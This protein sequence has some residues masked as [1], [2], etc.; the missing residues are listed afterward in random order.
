MSVKI[1]N[2]EICDDEFEI[3]RSNQKYCAKCRKNPD[4]ARKEYEW[5]AER[6]NRHAGWNDVDKTLKTHICI[7]CG[8]EFLSPYASGGNCSD[9]CKKA[10]KIKTARCE[11]C[12]VPLIEHGNKTGKGYCSEKCRQKQLS[13]R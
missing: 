11:V 13:D 5:A 8:K 6:L 10:Y 7:T 9:A 3:E 1:K 2:C 4:K 12:K